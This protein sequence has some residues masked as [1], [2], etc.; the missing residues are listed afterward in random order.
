VQAGLLAA[1]G[2]ALY[3][4]LEGTVRIAG[5]PGAQRRFTGS[6]AV[7]PARMPVTSWLDDATPAV[8]VWVAGVE[9][10]RRP[11]WAQPPFPLD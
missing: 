4:G 5:L 3:A 11:W 6:H 9:L 2:S 8:S 7:D 10:S 1:V